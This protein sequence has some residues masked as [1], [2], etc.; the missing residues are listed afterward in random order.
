MLGVVLAWVSFWMARVI[1]VGTGHCHCTVGQDLD[2][3]QKNPKSTKLFSLNGLVPDNYEYFFETPYDPMAP[4][5][6]SKYC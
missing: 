2:N 1:F 5:R 6:P 4:L 3:I